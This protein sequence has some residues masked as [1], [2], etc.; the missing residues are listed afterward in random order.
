MTLL[1]FKKSNNLR[2]RDIAE[3]TGIPK[4]TIFK[5]ATDA[6]YCCKLVH[7]HA[8]VR[9]SNGDIGYSDLLTGSDC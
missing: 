1:E 4:T 2:F 7:A 5:I 3:A 8:L 9:F 6:G